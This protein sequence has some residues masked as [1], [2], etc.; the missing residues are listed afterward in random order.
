MSHPQSAPSGFDSETSFAIT[1]C[2]KI[3]IVL[4]HFSKINAYTK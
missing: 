3:N 4:F 1:P 2:Y